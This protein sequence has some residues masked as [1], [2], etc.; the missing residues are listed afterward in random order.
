MVTPGAS[1][2]P[3]RDQSGGQEIT[4]E[5][6]ADPWVGREIHVIPTK[7]ACEAGGEI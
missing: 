2:L 3:A 1:I 6:C 4:R 7:A 5:T